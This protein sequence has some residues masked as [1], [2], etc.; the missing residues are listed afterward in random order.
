MAVLLITHDLGVVANMAEE[1]VVAHHGRVVESGTLR[2]HLHAARQHPYLKALLKAVPHFDMKPGE[3]L[4]PIREITTP[5]ERLRGACAARRQAR[6]HARSRCATSPSASACARSCD[7]C[8]APPRRRCSRSSD[9][10]FTVERGECLGLVGESGSGKTTV[11]KA[12]MRA[13]P[14]DEGEILL[15]DRGGTDRPR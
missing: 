9:V 13:M 2:R 15:H 14:M 12:I 4:K 1:V 7:G 11:S 6:R 5:A 3:R 10:S 8:R